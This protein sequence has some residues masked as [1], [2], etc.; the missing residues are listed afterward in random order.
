MSEKKPR[1]AGKRALAGIVMGLLGKG[2]RY[3]YKCDERVREDMDGIGEEYA[4]KLMV[5]PIGP[6]MLFG[7]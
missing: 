5:E 6:A 4:I 3:A 1:K 7:K 2:I